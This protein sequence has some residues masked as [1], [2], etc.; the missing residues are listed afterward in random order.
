MDIKGISIN[1]LLSISFTLFTAF[2]LVCQL[3]QTAFST[4]TGANATSNMGGPGPF[5]LKLDDLPLSPSN[6]TISYPD[7]IT[8]VNA[9]LVLPPELFS[10]YNIPLNLQYQY[11]ET[12]EFAERL[13]VNHPG[14]LS[15]ETLNQIQELA[16]ALKSH[17]ET[18]KNQIIQ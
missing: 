10:A 16:P 13:L 8:M 17:I 2:I 15:S 5:G 18:L 9:A 11:L 14:N 6:Q 7:L 1:K 4:V 3:D 12:L